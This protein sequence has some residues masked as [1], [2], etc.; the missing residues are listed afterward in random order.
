MWADG[1]DVSGL[2]IPRTGYGKGDRGDV[3]DPAPATGQHLAA[4]A[5]AYRLT[6]REMVWTTARAMARGFGL[7]DIGERPGGGVAM[8]DAAPTADPEVIFALLDIYRVV[9]HPDYIRMA[10][11]VADRI[12]AERFDGVFFRPSQTHVLANFNVIEPWAILALDAVLR[13]EPEKI[14]VYI[15]SRGYIHGRFDEHGR[16]YDNNVIWSAKK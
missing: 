15:P 9:S 5:R 12:V 4:Y 11:K 1:T 13:G 10:R 6:K 16:T 2:K 8:P 14:P 7:G 3:Y